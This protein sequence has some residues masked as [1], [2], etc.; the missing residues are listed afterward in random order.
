MQS[1]MIKQ[2]SIFDEMQA[3]LQKMEDMITINPTKEALEEIKLENQEADPAEAEKLVQK[4]YIKKLTSEHELVDFALCDHVND[5]QTIGDGVYF[6][7]FF[8]KYLTIIFGL[9][10]LVAIV[11]LVI[12]IIGGGMSFASQVD[13]LLATTLGNTERIML[14]QTE[15]IALNSTVSTAESKQAEKKLAR[16]R[17]FYFVQMASDMLICLIIFIGYYVLRHYINKKIRESQKK[18][19]SVKQY[20]V[21]VEGLPERNMTEDQVKEYFEKFHKVIRCNLAYKYY[22]CLPGMM[23][24]A[25]NKYQLKLLANKKSKR[26]DK[27]KATL[28][29]N[30]AK[31][32]KDIS[33][34]MKAY[35]FDISDKTSFKVIGAFVTFDDPKAPVDLASQFKT[36]YRRNFWEKIR[37]MKTHIRDKYLFKGQKLQFTRP[38]HPTNIY[39][40]NL[41]RSF[42]SKFFKGLL[43]FV[44][45]ILILALSVSI[46]IFLTAITTNDQKV[47]TCD[48]IAVTPADIIAT[49]GPDRLEKIY[50]YCSGKKLTD[51]LNDDTVYKYCYQYYLDQLKEIGVSLGSGFA[52]TIINLLSEFVAFH[53][54]SFIGF[55]SVSE[56]VTQKVIISFVLQYL[57]TGFVILVIYQRISGWSLV[58]FLNGVFKTEV[59]KIKRIFPDMSRGWYSKVGSKII[60]PIIIAVF[61]PHAIKF[62]WLTFSDWLNRR[63]ARKAKS[64]K[65]YIKL[66]TPE[67]F[68][69]EARYAKLLSALFVILTFSTGM[70]LLFFLYFLML[71]VMYWI[72]KITCLRYSGKPPLYSEDLILSIAK[73]IPAALIIHMIFGIYI[74]SNEEIFP[75]NIS[76]NNFYKEFDE[77]IQTSEFFEKIFQKCYK[78]LPYT[79]EMLLFLVIFLL[80]DFIDFIVARIQAG[81]KTKVMHYSHEIDSYTAN[82]KR[83]AFF[84]LPNYNIALNP[85]YRELLKAMLLQFGTMGDLSKNPSVVIQDN[86]MKRQPSRKE[87]EQKITTVNQQISE[88]YGTET[89]PKIDNT[90]NVEHS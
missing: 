1:Q 3:D 8:T 52:L 25:Q 7:F 12:N 24:M 13:L 32:T 47:I 19:V 16:L 50:C 88:F 80:E 46:N 82:Y 81:K 36:E 60:L 61:S 14:N 45:F 75:S 26:V 30:I 28:Q 21:W 67:T 87:T 48:T 84:S 85:K 44:V 63:K 71:L 18:N 51:I 35:Q 5:L 69:V 27:Q 11:P 34:T 40:E 37:C 76:F 77:L 17:I 4:Y 66:R 38:D 6:Y 41:E 64:L 22:G 86:P 89:K 29:T 49:T 78:C 15:L 83:I 20:T 42:K 55:V 9:V 10:V 2:E 68:L 23:E 58:E 43:A 59:I 31:L 62:I 79:L 56:V 74:F 54:I 65:K 53:L 39:W 70:P 72:D 90:V 33:G 73:T 57:N